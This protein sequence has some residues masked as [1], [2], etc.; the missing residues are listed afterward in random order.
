MQAPSVG[1]IVHFH[2][3]EEL[4]AARDQNREPQAYAGIIT[5]VYADPTVKPTK[6][7]PPAVSSRVDLIVFD[8]ELGIQ[9]K[10]NVMAQSKEVEINCWSWPPFVPP[11]TKSDPTQ[12]AVTKDTAQQTA[13]ASGTEDTPAAHGQSP[14]GQSL[15]QGKAH[16]ETPE[17]P[18]HETTG[19]PTREETAAERA[20]REKR[21]AEQRT[22]STARR[23]AREGD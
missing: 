14:S 12:P 16:P 18:Q 22:E 21:E 1:R 11:A 13:K 5:R 10:Q 8:P 4:V 2:E 7:A 9:I 3:R 19:G 17:P 6:G 15:D 20:E 23:P